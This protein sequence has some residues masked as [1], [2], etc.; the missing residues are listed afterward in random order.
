MI[1]INL[2]KHVHTPEQIADGSIEIASLRP[3]IDS[4][5]DYD[6]LQSTWYAGAMAMV[7]AKEA[8]AAAR[9][10][11]PETKLSANIAGAAW[12]II[13]LCAALR[14][15]GISPVCSFSKRVCTESLDAEGKTTLTYTFQHEGWVEL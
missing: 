15:Y 9:A 7:L 2:T 1:V 14:G 3:F 12:L 5:Q 4:A 8:H 10:I 13:P 11:L 6:S